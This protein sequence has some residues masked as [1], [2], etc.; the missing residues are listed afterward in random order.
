MKTYY[1]DTNLFVRFV[2][3]DGGELFHLAKKYVAQAKSGE[4][5]IVVLAEILIEINYVLRKVYNLSR[6]E[7]GEY[8]RSIIET[9]YLTVPEREVL[10]VALE[11]YER[12]NAD[13]IDVILYEKAKEANAEVL[14]FDKAD[15]KKIKKLDVEEKPSTK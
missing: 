7:V 8:L 10:I 1:A 6:K 15:F 2:M 5:E 4:I 3:Q 9:P 14:S 13:L 11:K 12:V